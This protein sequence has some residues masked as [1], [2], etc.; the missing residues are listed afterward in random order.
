MIRPEVNEK[1]KRNETMHK[2]HEDGMSYAK[3]AE[4]FEL[5]LSRTK[6]IIYRQKRLEEEREIPKRK[7]VWR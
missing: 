3:V 1:P 7:T 5:S 6:E 2:A 4:V